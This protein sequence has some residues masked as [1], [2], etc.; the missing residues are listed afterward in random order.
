MILL[1]SLKSLGW[2]EYLLKFFKPLMGTFGL[3]DRTAMMWVAAII[4]GLFFG[5]AVIIE[6]AKKGGLTREELE[7][8]HISIGINHSMVEDPALFAVLGLNA[9][10]LW[11]PRFVM[12][13]I[14]VQTY[15]AI[16]YLKHKLLH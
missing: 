10:W 14:A 4:F 7:R 11:V 5:G 2:I 16:K 13:I 3:S 1:E 9:F 8:L 15:R 12:A 6:E